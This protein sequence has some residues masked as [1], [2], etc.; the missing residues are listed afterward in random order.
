MALSC[1]WAVSGPSGW[2]CEQAGTSG[3]ARA[4]PAVYITTLTTQTIFLVQKQMLLNTQPMSLEMGSFGRQKFL[5][6][7]EPLK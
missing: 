1:P 7:R 3:P 4:Q 6:C 5:M 2:L